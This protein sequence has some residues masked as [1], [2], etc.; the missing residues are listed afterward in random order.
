MNSN[1]P[2]RVFKKEWIKTTNGQNS[3]LFFLKLMQFSGSESWLVLKGK[4]KK[5]EK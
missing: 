2:F 5:A 4:K 3:S 1:I